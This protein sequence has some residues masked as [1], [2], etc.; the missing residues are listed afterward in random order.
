MKNGMKEEFYLLFQDWKTSFKFTA[1]NFLPVLGIFL[2]NFGLLG[3]YVIFIMAGS[4]TSIAI[5][6]PSY[7]MAAL[8]FMFVMLG[9]I[10]VIVS[11]FIIFS[12]VS[13]LITSGT[14]DMFF[15][16]R[17]FLPAKGRFWSFAQAFLLKYGII[18]IC[19]IMVV[20]PGIIAMVL[21]SMV[22][23]IVLVEGEPAME[24]IRKS[25]RDGGTYILAILRIRTNILYSA[26]TY[27]SLEYFFFGFHVGLFN[28]YVYN[29]L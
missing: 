3:I 27:L 22:E 4:F 9:V 8:I 26:N 10:W 16:K 25:I 29:I 2:V 5:E 1:N 18:F 17:A 15:A 11:N 28:Q 19:T 6:V 12:S 13:Y 21:L 20:F 7:S 14:K 24:A 23:I